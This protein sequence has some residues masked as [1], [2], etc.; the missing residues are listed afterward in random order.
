[1]PSTKRKLQLLAA[2]T[3]L[4][5][6]ALAVGC[7]GFFRNPQLISITVGPP[8]ANI[9]QGTTLQMSAIGNFDDGST[10]TLTSDVA[11]FSDDTNIAPIT[12]GG[13]VTGQN[14]GTANITASQSAISGTTTITV[15]LNNVTAITISPDSHTIPLG[16]SN[17]YTCAATV[18]GGPPV[19]VSSSVNWTVTDSTGAIATGI[20]ITNGETP[21]TVTV[22]NTAATGNYK[23]NASYTTSTATFTDTA[24][25][26]VD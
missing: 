21:A 15:T 14:S 1:M 6:L 8:G 10:N 24:D 3:A 13:R 18:S 25:L 22:Q 9:Q 4:L 20:T 11:W 2:F 5:S 17:T 7:R 16:G 19:D 12:Q 26:I 23:V